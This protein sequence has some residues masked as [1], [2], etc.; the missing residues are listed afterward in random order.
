LNLEENHISEEA[1]MMVQQGFAGTF[2]Q[3]AEYLAKII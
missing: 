2:D 3:L 1:Q